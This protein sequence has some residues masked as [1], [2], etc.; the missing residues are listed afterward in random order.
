MTELQRDKYVKI[1]PGENVW[2]LVSPGR[3]NA[4]MMER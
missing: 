3:F 2:P 4:D 1:K